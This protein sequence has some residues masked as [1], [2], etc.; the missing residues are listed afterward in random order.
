MLLSHFMGEETEALT[1]KLWILPKDPQLVRG[2]QSRDLH[3]SSSILVITL[4]GLQ[5][6][7]PH[8]TL[9]QCDFLREAI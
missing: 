3:L 8:S 2:R 9:P 5:M 6:C 1:D 4:L 7:Q